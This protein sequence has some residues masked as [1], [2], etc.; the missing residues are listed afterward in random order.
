MRY[1]LFRAWDILNK[2]MLN[3]DDI[4]HLP[5]WEVFPGT[6][7]QRPYKVMQY[8]GIKDMDGNKIYEGDVILRILPMLRGQMKTYVSIVIFENGC[9][10]LKVKDIK[11]GYSLTDSLFKLKIIGNIFENEEEFKNMIIDEKQMV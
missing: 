7:E 5:I 8:T 3:Y 1:S 2:R 10:R 4:M 9:F 11:E 6:P